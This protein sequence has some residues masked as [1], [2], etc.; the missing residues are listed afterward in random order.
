MVFG[1]S[2]GIAAE[3]GRLE[4]PSS[5]EFKIG[6]PLDRVARRGS[7]TCGKS[8]A[9]VELFDSR[10]QFETRRNSLALIR[11]RCNLRRA[12]MLEGLHKY[13]RAFMI[14]INVKMIVSSCDEV[15]S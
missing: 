14:L 10:T 4:L 15:T 12:S 2:R 1:E 8:V 13:R 7:P 6:E 11:A 9:F 5:A 3:Y